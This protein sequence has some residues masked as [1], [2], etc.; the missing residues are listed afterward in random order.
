MMRVVID[1]NVLVAGIRSSR[2]ASARLISLI[3]AEK[4]EFAVSLALYLEYLDV[5]TRAENL[6]LGQTVEDAIDFVEKIVSLSH[7]LRVNF[8]WRPMLPD[9]D[10]DFVLEL[11]IAAG[12]RYIVTFNKRDFRGADL[13]GIELVTPAE[14]LEIIKKQ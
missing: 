12:S 14:F 1:T 8:P 4:F 5:L 7:K 11:A 3:R 2:G 13:F 6:A 10:D 9:P